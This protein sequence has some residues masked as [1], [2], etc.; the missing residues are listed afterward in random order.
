ML[1]GTVYGD[2]TYVAFVQLDRIGYCLLVI[3]LQPEVELCDHLQ[4]NEVT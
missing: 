1:G 3:N 2:K 4:E